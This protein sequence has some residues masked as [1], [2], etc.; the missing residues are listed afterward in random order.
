MISTRMSGTIIA[1]VFAL[2][3]AACSSGDS[4]IGSPTPP[5]PAGSATLTWNGPSTNTDSTALADLAGYR[6]YRSTTSGSYTGSPVAT[7]AAPSTGGGTATATVSNLASGTHYFVVRAYD[8]SGNES[9]NA[10]PGER[11]KTIP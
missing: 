11:S 10:L 2:T 5:P 7:V 8:T 4:P 6:V 9:A 3:L 1:V